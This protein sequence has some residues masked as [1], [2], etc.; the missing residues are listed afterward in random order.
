MKLKGKVT[1]ITGASHG[2]GK[3][4]SLEFVKQGAKVV[5]CD[6]D[7][8]EGK[9]VV[10]QIKHLGHEAVFLKCDVT[11]RNDIQKIVDKTI[12]VYGKIDVL[13]NCAG[14][15]IQKPIESIKQGDCNQIID[16]NLKGIIYFVSKVTEHMKQQKKGKIVSVASVFGEVGFDNASLYSA[17]SGGII[18]LTRSL[19]LELVKYKI[20][21]NVVSPGIVAT[22]MLDDVLVNKK[23][24][25]NLLSNIPLNRIGTPEEIVDAIVF[26][27]SN[28]SDFITG[29]NLVVDGGWLSH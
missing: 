4:T 20:N 16:T 6:I 27:A 19:A 8:V 25:K 2:I 24:R 7:V 12:E 15:F 13:L 22:H 14:L 18:N 11:K 28:K 5:L 26:L 3:A 9:R 29:H 1:I 23:K 21:V 17:S 10:E